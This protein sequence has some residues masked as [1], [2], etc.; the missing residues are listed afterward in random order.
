[1]LGHPDPQQ[2]TPAFAWLAWRL[3]PPQSAAAFKQRALATTLPERERRAALTAL[4]FNGSR[5]AIQGIVETAARAEGPT[6]ADAIWW[7][8]NRK[9]N[10]WKEYSLDAEL[11]QR[12][13]YDPEAIELQASSM[14]EP[15]V[16]AAPTLQDVLARKGNAKRGKAI[17]NRCTMCHRIGSEGY[18]VGPE[19]SAFAHAQTREVLTQSI[20]QPS[21]EIAHGFGASEILTTD[22][23]RIE[24][25][26]VSSGNPVVIL[27]A[28]GLTQ[29]V[30]PAKIK[31]NKP[32]G[33]SLMWTPQALGL[34]AQD[35]AD[36]LEYLRS[37]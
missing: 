20:L 16:P 25:L 29:L 7:L 5:G 32:L 21:D 36:L 3:H 31:S 17:I 22:D 18:E 1:M 13:I 9:D 28:G 2:W 26:V 34:Q 33:R 12:G 8:L 23:L 11:K 15:T 35:V 27:C 24:G 30:P 10:A 19:L 6:K 37:L 14:P 4:A